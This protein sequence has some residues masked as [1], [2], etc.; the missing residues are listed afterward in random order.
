[1]PTPSVMA[2]DPDWHAQADQRTSEI[3]LWNESVWLL[4][5]AEKQRRASRASTLE[6]NQRAMA[7]QEAE[8]LD[9]DRFDRLAQC[10]SG[11]DPTTN[12]GNGFYG[13]FQF[14]LASWH[15]A[16]GTGYPH[17][18]SYAEQKSIAMHWA[19]ITNPASQWPVCWPRS[20]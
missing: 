4:T 2:A 9:G 18:H 17:E 5:I 10:E 14:M 6:G 13:A 19:S 11:G 12:T 8:Q 16:G 3:K 15:S 1:M 20:A 7:D